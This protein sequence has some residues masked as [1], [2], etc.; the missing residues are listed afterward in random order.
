MCD[1]SAG[2]FMD[3]NTQEEKLLFDFLFLI[4]R[5]VPNNSIPMTFNY[6]NFDILLNK[7][8]LNHWDQL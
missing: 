7:S 2:G 1:S 8:E 6:I 5:K 4:F 3:V